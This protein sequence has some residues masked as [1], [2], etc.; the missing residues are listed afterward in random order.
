MFTGLVQTVGRILQV[1]PGAESRR[2]RVAAALSA[3]ARR[4]GSSVA[5][6]GVCL[7]L[8]ASTDR[9]FEAEASFE[10]LRRTTL[11]SVQAGDRVNL[12]PALC[13]GEA[14]AG[15]LVSGHVDGVSRLR[16]VQSR[17]GAR[18]CE[19]SLDTRFAPLVAEK[20]SICVA[21]VSLTVNSVSSDTFAV[22]LVPHTLH[23]TTLGSLQVGDAVNMEVDL[24]A[25]YV[26]RLL[27]SGGTAVS[28]GLTLE[29]LAHGGFLHTERT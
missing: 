8:T 2:L 29:S 11:G 26:A 7:T 9:S 20:G 5:V 14:L 27:A 19:F 24:L 17:G 16:S 1:T 4:I 18:Q 23:A 3:S 22:G 15:H 10:T 13:V 21:G 12:E 6:D 28:T 25:R